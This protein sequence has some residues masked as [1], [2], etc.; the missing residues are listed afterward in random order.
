MPAGSDVCARP[1]AETIRGRAAPRSPGRTAVPAEAVGGAA[2]A[3]ARA[4][5]K[6]AE[7]EAEAEA[8]EAA[9]AAGVAGAVGAVGARSPRRLE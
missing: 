2:C 7:A 1:A 6:V 4:G 5:E 3:V 9:E 8:V